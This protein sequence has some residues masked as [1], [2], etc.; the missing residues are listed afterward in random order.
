[1]PHADLCRKAF[2]WLRSHGHMLAATEIGSGPDEPDAIGFT[3]AGVCT[4][5]ECKT[6]RADFIRDQKKWHRLQ[7]V[8]GIRLGLGDR[9]YYCVLPGIIRTDDDLHGWGVLA[10]SSHGI[11]MLSESAPFLSDPREMAAVMTRLMRVLTW[12]REC[13]SG[14]SLFGVEPWGVPVVDDVVA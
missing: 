4:Y 2:R 6:S 12:E 7:A 1:M 9:R 8:A 10:P 5:I 13:S 11:R 3:S 14:R